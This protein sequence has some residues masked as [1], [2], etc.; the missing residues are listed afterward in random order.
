[1]SVDNRGDLRIDSWALD[2]KW[3][4]LRVTADAIRPHIHYTNLFIHAYCIAYT[5]K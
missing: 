4:K 3:S 5:V 2:I 1:M